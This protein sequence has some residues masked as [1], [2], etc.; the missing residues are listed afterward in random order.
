MQVPPAFE[1]YVRSLTGRELFA[2]RRAMREALVDAWPHRHTSH[3]ARIVC[4]TNVERLR[5][6]RAIFPKVA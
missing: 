6:I 3:G 1:Q 5:Q 4:R 2:E